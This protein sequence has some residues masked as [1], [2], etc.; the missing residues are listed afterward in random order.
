MTSP[1]KIQ[2]NRANARAS[3]G[4]KTARGRAHAARNSRRYGLSLSIFA[5]P[6]LS[7]Q[8]EAFA[9]EIA[10]DTSDDDIYQ[11]A[12]RVAAAQIDLQ[13]VR[14]A[15]HQLLC[16]ALADPYYEPRADTRA[17]MKVI[18]Q[19]LTPKPADVPLPAFIEK[20]LTTTPEGPAKLAAILSGETKQ[21]AAMDR[22]ERRALSRRKFA[23]RAFDRA[24]PRR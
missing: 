20:Y 23:I 21:L 4:P 16:D 10:G 3:T 2:A 6:A 12:R 17:K 13:R 11:F 5:D 9:R 8:V 7:E 1:R 24:R 15:R 22:Y 18:K 19:L 14:N